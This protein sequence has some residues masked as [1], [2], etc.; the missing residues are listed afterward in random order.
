MGL[1][2]TLKT[3]SCGDIIV[4]RSVLTRVAE[5]ELAHALLAWCYLA[6]ACTT[7]NARL[8]ARLARAFDRMDEH[9]GF[10]ARTSLAADADTM[11]AHGYLAMDERRRVA[12][13]VLTDVV[14]PAARALFAVAESARA[15]ACQCVA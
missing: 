2:P 6:W 3:P 7:G 9:V 10:G 15:A 4:Q 13:A 14:R 1:P 12:A 8:R 5:Q 11:R